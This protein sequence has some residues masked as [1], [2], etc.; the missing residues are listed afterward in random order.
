[1]IRRQARPPVPLGPPDAILANGNIITLDDAHPRGQAIA[2]ADGRIIAVGDDVQIGAL[3]TSLTER[4]DLGG[5]TILP[6]FIDA[7]AHVWHIGHEMAKVDLSRCD[8]ID[9]VLRAIADRARATPRGAWIEASGMWHESALAE[10]RLP[11]RRELDSVTP[12][13]P[14]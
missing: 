10:R 11:T 5:R 3:A 14:V 1:M 12:D 9:D 6:G 13:H 7:H 8:S 4:I 2:I